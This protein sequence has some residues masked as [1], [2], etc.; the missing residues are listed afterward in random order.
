MLETDKFYKQLSNVI[1]KEKEYRVIVMGNWNAKVGR[2]EI[3]ANIVGKHG[4]GK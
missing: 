4:F 3:Q 2:E 1:E